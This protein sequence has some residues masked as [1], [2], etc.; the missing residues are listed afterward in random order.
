[1]NKEMIIKVLNEW[2]RRYIEEPKKF[3]AEFQTVIEY[4]NEVSENI[5]PSYGQ[6][7]Y[8]YMEKLEKDI[9]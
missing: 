8:A 3:R 6:S 7:G 2:M 4:L 9:Q 5:E 1:M